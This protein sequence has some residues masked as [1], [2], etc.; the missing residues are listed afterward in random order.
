MQP[1]IKNISRRS[2]LL[3]GAA[4]LGYAPSAFGS[5]NI[6]SEKTFTVEIEP[7]R[8]I[9]ASGGTVSDV[10]IGG[11]L[12]RIHAFTDFGSHSF[13][14]SDVGSMGAECDFLVVANGG[15]GARGNNAGGGGGGG[16]VIKSEKIVETGH[17]V[18]AVGDSNGDSM[19]FEFTSKKGGDG[20]NA[21][22]HPQSG[23]S[24]GGAEYQQEP[25][26]RI[27]GTGLQPSLSPGIG[28]GNNGDRA[29]GGAGA[30]AVGSTAGIGIDFSSIFGNQYG[31]NGWFAGG[32]GNNTGSNPG[33]LGGGGMGGAGGTSLT[34]GTPGLPNTGGGGGASNQFADNEHPG[35]RVGGSGIIL[36]RYP[37]E[38]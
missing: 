38:N 14:I 32:G 13:N 34:P 19:I 16:G 31:E 20:G 2:L 4:S 36:I 1:I 15:S 23:G 5:P 28:Y 17:H 12:F 25:L 37:L 3:T 26:N 11:R 7:P 21:S 33:G 35:Q 27:P 18:L 22:S 8:P 10:E 24:G 29:G 9:Q 30:S 6:L